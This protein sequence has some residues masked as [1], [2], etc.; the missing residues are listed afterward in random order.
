MASRKKITR[1]K[2][3]RKKKTVK[4]DSIT[5]KQRNDIRK[6]FAK[7]AEV[8]IE[9]N[10][11]KRH[12]EIGY[13]EVHRVNRYLEA[14]DDKAEKMARNASIAFSN[15]IF[16]VLGNRLCDYRYEEPYDKL[17]IE[18]Y[19]EEPVALA[20]ELETITLEESNVN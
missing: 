1:K 4:L 9:A 20:Y 18:M 3:T 8:Q 17:Y 5:D 16:K 11:I 12:V 13:D 7:L 14:Q 2:T 15:F 6:S 10:T 19:K